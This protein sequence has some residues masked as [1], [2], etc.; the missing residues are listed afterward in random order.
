MANAHADCVKA[1]ATAPQAADANASAEID[2]TLKRKTIPQTTM[3]QTLA[4]KDNL[5]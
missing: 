2:A 3:T 1:I 5:P 4:T